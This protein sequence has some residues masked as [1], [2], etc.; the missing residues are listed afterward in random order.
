MTRPLLLSAA[1]ALL[2]GC[3]SA[4]P[5]PEEPWSFPGKGF[6]PEEFLF[7]NGAGKAVGAVSS[8][9]QRKSLSRDAALINAWDRTSSRL[10]SLPMKSGGTVRDRLGDSSRLRARFKTLV[11]SAEVVSTRWSADGTASVVIR[12]PKDRIHQV[13]GTRP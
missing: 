13:L 8:D 1:A 3:A 2:L 9:T 11:R 4:S 7:V 5:A 12:L 10:K 6:A